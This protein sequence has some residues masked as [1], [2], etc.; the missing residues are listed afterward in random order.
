MLKALLLMPIL[1]KELK[2]MVTV[3]QRARILFFFIMKYLN[4]YCVTDVVPLEREYMTFN[5]CL[6][7]M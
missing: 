4:S 1:E 3:D 2:T 5:S 6:R 7:K